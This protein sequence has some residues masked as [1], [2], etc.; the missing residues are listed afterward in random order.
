MKDQLLSAIGALGADE[1][2]GEE[3]EAVVGSIAARIV[4][5]IRAGLRFTLA[6]C[7]SMSELS[8][9]AIDLAGQLVQHELADRIAGS[10]SGNTLD[11]M[12]NTVADTEPT[13]EEVFAALAE[14]IRSERAPA[15]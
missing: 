14:S 1:P 13:E 15:E 11:S 5:L 2:S 8:L 9:A 3:R 10:I 6:D 4:P 7:A 12:F